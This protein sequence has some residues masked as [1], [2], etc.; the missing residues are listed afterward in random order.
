MG[1]EVERERKREQGVNEVRV[2]EGT[3]CYEKKKLGKAEK[4]GKER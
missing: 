1:S 2:G 4:I 3:P